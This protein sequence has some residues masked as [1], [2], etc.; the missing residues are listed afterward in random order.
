MTQLITIID[1]KEAY[2]ECYSVK[3]GNPGKK[4]LYV[5]LTFGLSIDNPSLSL[6]QLKMII[7]TSWEFCLP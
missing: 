4:C 2:T 7:N 5:Q 1:K 6:L 3:R